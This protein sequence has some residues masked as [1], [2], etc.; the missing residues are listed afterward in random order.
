MWSGFEDTREPHGR[1]TG[2][3]WWN[4]QTFG[5]HNT[6]G[7]RGKS[8]RIT[9]ALTW[10]DNPW[11]TI[12]TSRDR[13][14]LF[15]YDACSAEPVAF[16]N[17]TAIADFVD[18]CH[19]SVEPQDIDDRDE[20]QQKA[21]ALGVNPPPP[22]PP[23]SRSDRASR[24]EAPSHSW[25]DQTNQDR[26]SWASFDRD[27]SVWWSFLDDLGVNTT[28]RQTLFLFSTAFVSWL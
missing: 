12:A 14:Q 17:W 10:S 18:T 4:A 19:A 23:P 13:S 8:E 6:Y 5:L 25:S 7:K 26:P 11:T 1:G 22:P 21:D 28:A 2:K 16:A 20:H 3:R 27:V 24:A 9:L 15:G